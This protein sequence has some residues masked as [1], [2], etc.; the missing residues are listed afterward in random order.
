MPIRKPLNYGT[1]S[2]AAGK[3]KG[4][5]DGSHASGLNRVPFDGYVAEL[6]K[7]EMVIPERQAQAI[8]ESGGNINVD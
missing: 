1:I 5:F 8:R 4:L 7:G 6:H 3:V 2:N